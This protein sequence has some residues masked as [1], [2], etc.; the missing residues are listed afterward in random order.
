MM[1]FFTSS[2]SFV[3]I[4]AV[5]RSSRIATKRP[6]TYRTQHMILHFFCVPFARALQ[7][8]SNVS[9]PLFAGLSSDFLRLQLQ[10]PVA[11]LD[12][13]LSALPKIGRAHARTESSA[14]SRSSQDL[15][16]TVTQS[17]A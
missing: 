16:P 3:L 1:H 2:E 7:M 14:M 4:S 8:N 9:N 13:R 10:V 17:V 5:L 15:I 11:E 6:H 12:L